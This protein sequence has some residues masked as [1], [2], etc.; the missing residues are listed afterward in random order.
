MAVAYYHEKEYAKASLL[1]EG[2]LPIL[3]G[4]EEGK[5]GMFLYANALFYQEE[6]ILA[7]EY[8]KIFAKTYPRSKRV[9]LASYMHAHAQ[10]LNTEPYYLDPNPTYIA[11]EALQVFLETYSQSTYRDR[12]QHMVNDLQER[13]AK[14]SFHGAKQYYLMQY[15]KAA[16]FAFKDF[17]N[18]FP[19][20]RYVEESEYFRIRAQY[21]WAKKSIPKKQHERYQAVCVSYETF[22]SK[23]PDSNHAEQLSQIYARC[24]RALAAIRSKPGT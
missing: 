2:L 12:G 19:A 14:K 5:E 17:Q 11:L 21:A 16:L 23:Y 6:Y 8:F 24:L 13:L 18:T 22:L 7:A 9:E 20:S 3:R 10:Y 15:H 4:T 1:F